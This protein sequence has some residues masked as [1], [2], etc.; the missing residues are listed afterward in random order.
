MVGAARCHMAL[1][2]AVNLGKGSRYQ[3]VLAFFSFYLTGTI[4]KELILRES[5]FDVCI[6]VCFVLS[7]FVSELNL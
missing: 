4:P 3:R 1:V 5:V 7:R 6:H 2:F